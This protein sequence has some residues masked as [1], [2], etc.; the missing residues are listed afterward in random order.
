MPLAFHPSFTSTSTW[1]VVMKCHG[2]A[3]FGMRDAFEDLLYSTQDLH[4]MIGLRHHD[5]ER[6]AYSVGSAA[7]HDGFW[8][9]LVTS[10]PL[11]SR[12]QRFSL[13]ISLFVVC[14]RRAL[15]ARI[16]HH[17]CRFEVREHSIQIACRFRWKHYTATWCYFSVCL[18]IYFVIYLWC[19]SSIA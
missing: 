1:H 2:D 18:L 13:Q 8:Y 7:W 10:R 12:C 5:G 19:V 4:N 9:V 15:V 17:A 16:L 14:G 3:G 6:G 11:N